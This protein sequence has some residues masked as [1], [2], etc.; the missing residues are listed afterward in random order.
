MLHPASSVSSVLGYSVFS[1]PPVLAS[2]NEKEPRVWV[3]R[4]HGQ[5]P[6]REVWNIAPQDHPAYKSIVY[7]NKMRYRLMPY[8]YSLAGQTWLDDKIIMRGLV[9][10]FTEDSLARE[11]SDQYMFGPSLMVCPVY[12]YGA[13]SRDVYLPEGKIWYDYYTDSVY[14]GGQTI[15]ADAPYERI[16]LFVPSGAILISGNDVNYVDERAADVLTLD[17]YAGSDGQFMLYEDDGT[18]NAYEKGMFSVIPIAFTED[19]HGC[20]F[21]F[22]KISGDYRA[23]RGIRTFKVRYHMPDRIAEAEI[24]Y[25]GDGFVRYD[26]ILR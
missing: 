16:P 21:T 7:Y 22:G 14:W 12:E 13:T 24:N 8:I 18:T 4:A 11:V 1:I 15:E 20:V 26:M 19:E 10:D 25:T 9:M 17:M 6:L 5:F 23:F 2:A 3:Y